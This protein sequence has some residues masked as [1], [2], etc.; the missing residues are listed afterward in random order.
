LV[1]AQKQNV[2]ADSDGDAVSV[3]ATSLLRRLMD[4]L[5]QPSPDVRQGAAIALAALARPLSRPDNLHLANGYFLEALWLC[6]RALRHP[7]ADDSGGS[8]AFAAPGSNSGSS[9]GSLGYGRSLVRAIT[10]LVHHCLTRELAQQLCQSVTSYSGGGVYGVGDGFSGDDDD[11]GSEGEGE[12]V[13]DD[14]AL[15]GVRQ[16]SWISTLPALVMWLWRGTGGLAAAMAS[17]AA[18]RESMRLHARLAGAVLEVR[19]VRQ[20]SHDDVSAVDRRVNDL[21]DLEDEVM[22]TAAEAPLPPMGYSGRWLKW[23]C[24]RRGYDKLDVLAKFVFTFTVP[25][26][27]RG[28]GGGDGGDG[29]AQM[30]TADAVRG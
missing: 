15:A 26:L 23:R 8:G 25:S 14:G 19:R 20:S 11:G 7:L 9:S 10:A 6:V 21:M 24:V 12:G 30:D 17:S 5:M 18:R 16:R 29:G 27:D 22:G 4:R 13:G 1:W 28:G 2:L 3:N